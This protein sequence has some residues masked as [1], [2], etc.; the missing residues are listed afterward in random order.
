MSVVTYRWI[1]FLFHIFWQII[2]QK[3]RDY[4]ENKTNIPLWCLKTKRQFLTKFYFTNQPDEIY[5]KQWMQNI[6][7]DMWSP[8]EREARK[9]S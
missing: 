2:T 4:T 7:E 3:F 9:T 5:L 6:Q 8:D 1:D